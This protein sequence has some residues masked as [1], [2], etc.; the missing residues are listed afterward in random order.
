MGFPGVSDGKESTLSAGDL[1]RKA[2]EV[3]RGNVPTRGKCDAH[4]GGCGCVVLSR[5]SPV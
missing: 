2:P 4:K 1:G 3:R 5:F